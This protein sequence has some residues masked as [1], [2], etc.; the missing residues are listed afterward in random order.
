MPADQ[1]MI[2]VLTPTGGK[3]THEQEKTLVNGVVIDY[4]SK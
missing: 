1:A 4:N 2:L 3:I